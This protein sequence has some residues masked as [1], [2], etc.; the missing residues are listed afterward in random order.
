MINRRKFIKQTGMGAA[1]ISIAGLTRCGTNQSGSVKLI[2]GR[3]IDAHIHLT[4]GKLKKALQVMDDNNIRYAVII[5]SISG[6]DPDLY[7]G[8]KAFYEIINA[9]KPYKDRLGLHYTYDW[10]LAK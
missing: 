4:P 3:V 7:V 8:D 10:S 9:I 5:A 6:S 1:A 2:G